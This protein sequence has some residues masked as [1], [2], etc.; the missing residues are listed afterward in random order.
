MRVLPVLGIAAGLGLSVGLMALPAAAQPSALPSPPTPQEL[1][2]M[3]NALASSSMMTATL[4]PAGKVVTS[5]LDVTIP[6]GGQD[7]WPVC[8]TAQAGEVLPTPVGAVGYEAG[9]TGRGDQAVIQVVYDY[10]DAATAK[11]AWASVSRDA[12]RQCPGTYVRDGSRTSVRVGTYNSGSTPAPLTVRTTTVG[13]STTGNYV[14]LTLVGSSIQLIRLDAPSNPTTSKQDAEVRKLSTMLADRLA[15][16]TDL[17]LRQD[18]LTT[19]AEKAM[20]TESDVPATTPVT[21]PAKGGWYS[22]ISYLPPYFG[23]MLCAVSKEIPAGDAS[24]QVALGGEGGPVALPGALSQTVDVYPSAVAAQRAWK[25]LKSAVAT[26]SSGA[27]EPLSSTGTTDRQANGV[28]SLTFDG[29]PGVW[30]RD[31]TTYADGPFSSKTYTIHLLVGNA[32]QSVTYYT[33]VMKVSNVPLDQV[34]VNALA[35]QLATRWVETTS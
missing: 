5:R 21:R 23:P 29:I 1:V 10:A 13:K 19:A 26:C 18:A 28:S 33:S 4:L 25:A 12:V 35:E 16:A 2:T 8:Q 14:T 6:V 31:L 15:R 11:S 20:L 22:F 7:P 34:A 9:F 17:P 27:G 32:I 24:Y 3:T 30:S